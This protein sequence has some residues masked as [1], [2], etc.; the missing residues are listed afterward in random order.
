MRCLLIQGQ[1]G[2][3]RPHPPVFTRKKYKV[4]LGFQPDDLLADTGLR[5]AKP[6]GGSNSA[7]RFH[8]G[9]KDLKTT[10]DR[11]CHSI[12]V[13]YGVT[14]GNNKIAASESAC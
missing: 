2:L 3:S 10:N 7:A 4:Q 8:K 1:S 11:C 12:S 9:A 5:H 13:A 6:P 14:Q